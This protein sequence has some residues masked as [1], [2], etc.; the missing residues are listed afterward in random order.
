[1]NIKFR[2]QVTAEK[3]NKWTFLKLLSSRM[4]DYDYV[5]FK[6]NDQRI[7]GFPWNTFIERKGNAV[8]SGPL[9]TVTK[10]A[11]LRDRKNP[12]EQWFQFHDASE[13][14]NPP[15]GWMWST[16]LYAGISPIEVPI[17]EMYFVLFQGDFA[18]WFFPRV[19]TDEFLSQPSCWG[20]DLLWCGAAKEYRPSQV[21]C[22]L[23]PVVSLH[24]DSR[25][26]QKND[27]HNDDGLRMFDYFERN[28]WML[29]SRDW[30]KIID[31][32]AGPTA[33]ERRCKRMFKTL[34]H[35]KQQFDIEQCT[36]LA[37]LPLNMSITNKA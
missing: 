27:E 22:S 35:S 4:A 28:P 34:R 7:A 37:I 16:D 12:N 33:V 1:V 32:R 5:L 23:V 9:R 11:L 17:L 19:L 15:K 21:S 13:W 2:V 8:I 29:A 31:R 6:D 24:E 3:F 26:I 30:K 20:P 14:Q 18:H 25:Q 36:R 10:E